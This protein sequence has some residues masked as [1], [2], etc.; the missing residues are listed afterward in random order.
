MFIRKRNEKFVIALD[1]SS[2]MDYKKQIDP[3]FDLVFTFDLVVVFVSYQ[4]GQVHI[5]RHN[6]NLHFNN[7]KTAVKI[8]NKVN[9]DK[10]HCFHCI[11]KHLTNQTILKLNQTFNDLLQQQIQ[12]KRMRFILYLFSLFNIV[13]VSV[14]FP[15]PLI[16]NI[17]SFINV[18]FLFLGLYVDQFDVVICIES[19]VVLVSV[20]S[21]FYISYRVMSTMYNTPHRQSDRS[22]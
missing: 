13:L 8:L 11:S 21:F 7:M 4:L 22:D 15:G 6:G 5:H 16:L 9:A 18:I 10:Y 2:I 19:V 12:I 1:T 14:V 20:V 3:I 17:L